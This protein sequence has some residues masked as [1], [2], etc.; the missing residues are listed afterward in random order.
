MTL[1]DRVQAQRLHVFRRAEEL[2]S[3][4]TACREAGISRSLFYRLRKRY[5]LYGPDGLHPRRT[6]AR[7]GRPPV[8]AAHVERAGARRTLFLGKEVGLE[9]DRLHGLLLRRCASVIV[10]WKNTIR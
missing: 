7:P 1:E 3:V 4:T 5:A 9:G 8:V 10:P 2:G 6:K